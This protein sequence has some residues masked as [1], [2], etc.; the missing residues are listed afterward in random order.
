MSRDASRE[1]KRPRTGAAYEYPNGSSYPSPAHPHLPSPLE[2]P[3]HHDRRD[4]PPPSLPPYPHEPQPAY[5]PPAISGAHDPDYARSSIKHSPPLSRPIHTQ[6]QLQQQRRPS[7]PMTNGH[8]PHHGMP[9]AT[10]GDAPQHQTH[11]AFPSRT[12]TNLTPIDAPHAI[13]YGHSPPSSGYPTSAAPPP[14]SYAPTPSST[15]VESNR[16]RAARAAQACEACRHRKAKCDEGRPACGF[17]SE[18]GQDCKYRVVPPPKSD[19]HVL[20]MMNKLDNLQETI[21]MLL[22][23]NLPNIS[24]E[25]RARFLDQRPT[26]KS[27]EETSPNLQRASPEPQEET[28]QSH[29]EEAT[30]AFPPQSQRQSSLSSSNYPQPQSISIK[31]EDDDNSPG[32]LSIPVEHTTAA[33]KLMRWPSI[34]DL[35]SAV[36][37][38]EDYVIKEEENRGILRLY[39]RGEGRDTGEFTLSGSESGWA[40]DELSTPFP[41][42]HGVWGIGYA[43]P[44]SAQKRKIPFESA[45]G[46]NPDGTLKLDSATLWELFAS[47]REHIHVMHPFMDEVTT[48]HIFRQFDYRCNGNGPGPSPMPYQQPQGNHGQFDPAEL[49]P[50]VKRKR[51]EQQQ[52]PA[53]KQR[54][55]DPGFAI[56]R[57]VTTA[58]VLLILAL[59]KI[60]QHKEWLPGPVPTTTKSNQG[61]SPAASSSTESPGSIKHSPSATSFQPGPM[62]APSATDTSNR[63]ASIDRQTSLMNVDVIPGLAYYTY[64]CEILGSVIGGNDLPHVQA[65]LLA[66]LYAGQLCRVIE[67]WKWINIACTA[68]QLTIQ[69][70]MP[71]AKKCSEERKQTIL[72]VFWTC[73]QLESDILAE[74]NF[75]PSGI[76]R[77][78]EKVE[79]PSPLAFRPADNRREEEM[80]VIG[81]YYLAQVTL[82]KLLNRVHFHVYDK[83]SGGKPSSTHQ[84][85]YSI[86][87]LNAL[88]AQLE[89]WRSVLPIQLAWSNK[90]IPP[91]DI[92]AARLRAKYWGAHYIIYRPF[93][94][95]TLHP[96]NTHIPG[97]MQSLMSPTTMSQGSPPGKGAPNGGSRTTT[98]G[99]SDSFN[100]LDR[101]VRDACLQCVLAAIKSTCA[102]DG[103][104]GR[105]IVTNIFGTIHA[106]FGN[107]LVLNAAWRTRP[108][109]STVNTKELSTMLAHVM[110]RFH[111]LSRLSPALKIDTSILEQCQKTLLRHPRAIRDLQNL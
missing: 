27:S 103:I 21:N 6:Q 73:L 17:C 44:G 89:D 71:K 24:A 58:I 111:H 11:S 5:I 63:R 59:G 87:Q 96:I 62:S 26:V 9:M 77:Y 61:F 98:P 85:V 68:C 15:V 18:N 104:E 86:P 32:E 84:P 93:L 99:Q 20:Q 75:P 43:I 50:G 19:R 34:R 2:P 91:T 51:S 101:Q 22:Q 109:T 48:E 94:H 79:L 82:R 83:P 13:P 8:D 12:H 66:G 107:M 36:I 57:S 74:L 10:W 37:D 55:R 60:C 40:N 81:L 97:S 4:A 47:Y 102:F 28:R 38:D 56:E 67:S 49:N 29:H 105:P 46:L 54:V 95:H 16:R 100:G 41:Y 33:H 88:K 110:E 35:V 31:E 45:G 65:F 1:G 78:E 108:L 106:Q 7:L 53:S 30:P 39:G 90:E 42:S 76:S 70:A 23:A 52:Q 25:Q 14:P 69:Q 72:I 3:M 92:N 80:T 64:A